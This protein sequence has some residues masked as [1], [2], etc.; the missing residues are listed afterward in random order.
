MNRF[1][2][3]LYNE[4]KQEKKH[5][6]FGLSP[7][8]I[9]RP[10]NPPSIAGMDQYSELYADAKLWL[11][12]G[13]IDYFSPQLYWPIGRIQQSFPVLLGWWAS[14]NKQGRHL[15]PGIS[16]GRDTSAKTTT[17]TLNQ[18]MISRGMLPSSPG[19]VHWSVS[20]VTKNPAMASML[21]KGP[22]ALDALVPVSPWLSGDIP[23]APELS[24][25]SQKDSTHLSWTHEKES[26]IF[27]WVVYYEY[28][29]TRGY[30][31]LTRGERAWTLPNT[32]NQQKLTRVAVT[33]V[34]RS[35]LESPRTERQITL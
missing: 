33:A 15:W 35:S 34:N 7:F 23:K 8:G 3:R 25:E 24:I 28:G 27:K 2:K 30:Q 19:V 29:P 12:E 9:W 11:N 4:I 14:Q 1:I 32:V 10:K 16:V 6:K 31:I 26:D 18:I 17:E 21:A 5:V 20:S 13:W 22:Y